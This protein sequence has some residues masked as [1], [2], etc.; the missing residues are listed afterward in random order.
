MDTFN[1][2]LAIKAFAMAI[3]IV[4]AWSYALPLRPLHKLVFYSVGA[5]AQLWLSLSIKRTLED[6]SIDPAIATLVEI[7]SALGLLSGLLMGVTAAIGWV[8]RMTPEP[9]NTPPEHADFGATH[10]LNA[11]TQA[12]EASNNA[13]A[14]LASSEL[15]SG[16]SELARGCSVASQ[17]AGASGPQRR[18]RLLPR[19]ARR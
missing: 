3:V 8:R 17:D 18:R 5:P 2:I 14:Q 15:L 9:A 7:S 11:Q 4:T 19:M 13:L 12:R 16:H 10:A 6:A 1:A